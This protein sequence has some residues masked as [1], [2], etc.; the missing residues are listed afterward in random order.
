MVTKRESFRKMRNFHSSE[1]FKIH[2][3]EDEK[4]YVSN[5][6]LISKGKVNTF[7][8]LEYFLTSNISIFEL[9]SRNIFK[10]RAKIFRSRCLLSES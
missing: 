7:L 1:I 6:K 10:K 8:M 9:L 4:R 3:V 5:L 2:L